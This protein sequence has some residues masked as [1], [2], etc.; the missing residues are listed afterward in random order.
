MY[1]ERFSEAHAVLAVLNPAVYAAEQN[2]G[3]VSL[4]NYHRV[5]V[6]IHTGYL[7]GDVDVDFEQATTTAGAGAKT[8]D[9]G[10]KDVTVLGATDDN[11]VRII[12]I[13][14]EEFDVTGGFDCLNVELT[15]ALSGI[16]GVIVYGIVSRFKPVPT[17]LVDVIT[18]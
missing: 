15:P 7:L 10:G 16:I 4:A 2:T 13:R 14:T 8:L 17:T 3:Y 11:T 6:V 12:E 9:T 1:T 18:D 5:A